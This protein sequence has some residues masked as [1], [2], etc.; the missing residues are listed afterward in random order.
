MSLNLTQGLL[1]G[2]KDGLGGIKKIYL[3]KYVKYSRSLIVTT[4]LVLTSF[5][6]TDLYEFDVDNNPDFSNNGQE[7]EGGKFYDEKISLDFVGINLYNEFREFLSY[8]L[9]MI[10]Q[11]N[12]GIYRMLGAFNGLTVDTL[13]QVTGSAHSDFAG[14]RVS[15]DGL[16]RQPALFINDINALSFTIID[17]NFLLLENGEYVLTEGNKLI[18]IE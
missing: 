13:S 4:D 11:D 7:N 9:R 15:F 6:A 3:F 16:E 1:R 12:N 5:P 17:N 14:Y 10:V 18:H 8:D 2:C